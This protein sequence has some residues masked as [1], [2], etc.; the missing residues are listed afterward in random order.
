[1]NREFWGL[2]PLVYWAEQAGLGKLTKCGLLANPT[3]G[4]RILLGGVVT[5]MQLEPSE[6]LSGKICPPDC[7]ECIDVCPVKAIEKTGK[8]NHST[9]MSYANFN[10]LL[11]HLRGDQSWKEKFS[12]ETLMNTVGVDDHSCYSCFECL[13]ACP[14]NKK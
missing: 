11:S 3:Y 12:F 10:P 7:F 14:L 4:T 6:K 1:M 2:M 9:C 13:K 5:T 8:V